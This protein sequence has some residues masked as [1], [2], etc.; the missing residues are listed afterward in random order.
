[1]GEVDTHKGFEI[2]L[3]NLMGYNANHHFWI[4]EEKEMGEMDTQKGFE[5]DL[6]NLLGYNPNHHFPSIPSSR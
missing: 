1:M 3:G 2:D 6:G 5:I 4:W